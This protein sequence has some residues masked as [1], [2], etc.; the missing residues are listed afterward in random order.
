[1]TKAITLMIRQR[2][3]A[4]FNSQHRVAVASSAQAPI[5]RTEASQVEEAGVGR[6]A[7]QLRLTYSETQTCKDSRPLERAMECTLTFITSRGLHFNH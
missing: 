4:W 5:H 6:Q 1:M 3:T 7:Q 2:M